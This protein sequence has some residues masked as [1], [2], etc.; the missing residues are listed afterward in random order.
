MECDIPECKNTGIGY[1]E[2][3][4]CNNYVCLEH[5]V[6]DPRLDDRPGFLCLPCL[7]V[8]TALEANRILSIL[9]ERKQ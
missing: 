9:Q 6:D 3:P 5:S 4:E 1:C 7:Q 2:E 8:I